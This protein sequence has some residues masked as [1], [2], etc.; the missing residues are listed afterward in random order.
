MSLAGFS[1]AGSEKACARL[2]KKGPDGGSSEGG[3]QLFPHRIQPS[4]P[5]FLYNLER[6][7]HNP[8]AYEYGSSI[9]DF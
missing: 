9:L 5:I 1:T 6:F 7:Q 4:R 8:Q 3:P 2:S